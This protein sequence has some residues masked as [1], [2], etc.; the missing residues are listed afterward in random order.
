MAT[1]CLLRTSGGALTRLT[2]PGWRSSASIGLG[3]SASWCHRQK[4]LHA[5]VLEAGQW[6]AQEEGTPQGGS[7]S[8]LAA[9]ISLHDVLA[10]W[11]D[12]WRRQYA[13]GDGIIVRYADACSVG[14]EHRDD[15]ERCWRELQE[16]CGKFNLA[17]PPEKTRLS[18]CGR[19][20]VDRR[21]RRA[22]GTP[23]PFDFLGFTHIGSPTR[24]GKCTVRRKTMAQRLR[25]KLHAVK[26]TRRRRMHWPIP[27][28]GAWL[29]SVRLGHSRYYDVP[30]TGSLLTVCRDTIRR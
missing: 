8:P 19:F 10:L 21:R 24:K 15:A 4:W 25:K 17:L 16:R 20:A 1:G 6:H 28:Q 7:V 27:Q 9:N 18:E 30:R 13:R 2:T 23:A 12:R 3:T 26:E 22:Q 11:A 5:G 29:Q 14:C